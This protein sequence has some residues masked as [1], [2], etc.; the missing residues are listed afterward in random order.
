MADTQGHGTGS[1]AS[2]DTLYK[3]LVGQN[4]KILLPSKPPSPSLPSLPFLCS[5]TWG[6]IWNTWNTYKTKSLGRGMGQRSPK[7]PAPV[8]GWQGDSKTTPEI[9]LCLLENVS[10]PDLIRG[11]GGGGKGNGTHTTDGHHC[12]CLTL[13]TV[14]I[15]CS[16]ATRVILPQVPNSLP[17]RMLCLCLRITYLET[18]QEKMGPGSIQSCDLDPFLRGLT[19]NYEWGFLKGR[20]CS[21][22]NVQLAAP[23][24][25]RP[26]PLAALHPQQNPTK[27]ARPTHS[28]GVHSLP[29]PFC[30]FTLTLPGR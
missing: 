26:H 27:N 28:K 9:Q 24:P 19:Y 11:G 6:L 5:V 4:R 13:I 1:E 18:G 25:C 22:E 15:L 7:L 23:H 21:A 14:K 3:Q 17:N 29:L 10:K 30:L 16:N 2:P 12:Q 20:R 8:L